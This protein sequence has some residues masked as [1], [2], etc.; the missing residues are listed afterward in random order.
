[1]EN[2]IASAFELS[3]LF[4]LLG[5]FS[6]IISHIHFVVSSELFWFLIFH[7]IY[8]PLYFGM[9]HSRYD[10]AK[11]ANRISQYLQK[12]PWQYVSNPSPNTALKDC[13]LGG[14]KWIEESFEGGIWHVTTGC[15]QLIN[16]S[17]LGREETVVISTSHACRDLSETAFNKVYLLLLLIVE[18]VLPKIQTRIWQLHGKLHR[19]IPSF[20]NART[21]SVLPPIW[22]EGKLKWGW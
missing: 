12:K 7:L 20:Y 18:A 22:L 14:W 9:Q 21:H 13:N 17:K 6:V 4:N 5:L 2:K 10:K 1:M 8:F 3:L 11:G 15:V 16:H 19:L